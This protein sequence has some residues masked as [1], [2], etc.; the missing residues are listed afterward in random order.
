MLMLNV[1]ENALVF[2]IEAFELDARAMEGDPPGR[3]ECAVRPVMATTPPT[4]KA[5][6]PAQ[7]VSVTPG[8]QFTR[9]AAGAP[10]NP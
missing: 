10:P 3:F 1:W 8:G 7:L 4:V 6:P 9:S 2:T 5:P